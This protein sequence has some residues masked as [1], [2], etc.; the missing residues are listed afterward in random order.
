MIT[1]ILFI[2]TGAFEL[3]AKERFN[4]GIVKH[5]YKYLVDR[6]L[7]RIIISQKDKRFLK[8]ANHQNSKAFSY[9]H[10]P[11]K[12]APIHSVHH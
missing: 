2:Q 4:A 12:T 11:P 10:L 8:A 5:L 6:H 1:V 9:L 3:P 7:N